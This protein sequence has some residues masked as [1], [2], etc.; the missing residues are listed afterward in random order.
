LL[1]ICRSRS[2]NDI[3][4]RLRH[5]TGGIG[6]YNPT[7]D[8]K[9]LVMFPDTVQIGKQ[10]GITGMDGVDI[11]RI[12]CSCR[13]HHSG[14]G[15][16]LQSILRMCV[17]VCYP[18]RLNLLSIKRIGTGKNFIVQQTWL[19]RPILIVV[20]NTYLL[21]QNLPLAGSSTLLCHPPKRWKS[22]LSCKSHLTE[23]SNLSGMSSLSR[24]LVSITNL[25][26]ILT[27]T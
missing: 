25:G 18:C 1:L 4:T 11:G 22:G 12:T 16:S 2:C 8:G 21:S 6:F 9:P 10:F 3:I 13:E 20:L 24:N 26:F 5:R 23:S 14:L 27:F 15:A 17:D 19:F 7:G